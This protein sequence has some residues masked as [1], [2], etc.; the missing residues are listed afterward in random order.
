M[1][2]GLIDIYRRILQYDGSE[3]YVAFDDDFM[4][5]SD[6]NDDGVQIG[7]ENSEI[8]N[9]IMFLKY[10]IKYLTLLDELK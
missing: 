3:I 4:N 8:I 7:G 9:R 10:K 1:T 6:E 2:T 5:T